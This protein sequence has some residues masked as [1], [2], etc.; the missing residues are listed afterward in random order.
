MGFKIHFKISD[1][2]KKTIPHIWPWVARKNTEDRGFASPG[3]V[4]GDILILFLNSGE[5]SRILFSGG[6][7]FK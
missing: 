2:K 5:K 7:K 6:I 4:K 1:N 3:L